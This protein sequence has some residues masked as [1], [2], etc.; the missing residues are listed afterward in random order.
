V[1]RVVETPVLVVPL[2]NPKRRRAL[3][4]GFA[5]CATGSSCVSR[6]SGW[7]AASNSVSLYG[8]WRVD[9]WRFLALCSA[10]AETLAEGGGGSGALEASPRRRRVMVNWA[11]VG[12]PLRRVLFVQSQCE[13]LERKELGELTF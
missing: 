5:G 4:F 6:G 13:I 10:G 8:R 1:E 12:T 9:R 2:K 11:F 7:I 3:F